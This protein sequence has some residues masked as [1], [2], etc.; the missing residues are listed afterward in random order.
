MNLGPE[1]VSGSYKYLLVQSGSNPIT[2][3]ANA[4]VNWNAG[5]VVA[6]TGAQSING[7]KTFSSNVK[8]VSFGNGSGV[9]NAFGLSADAN[10]FGSSASVNYFGQGS[11]NNYFA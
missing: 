9:S 8:A 2:L 3:G 4:S 7:V 6:T 11:P 10:D 5:G 1:I